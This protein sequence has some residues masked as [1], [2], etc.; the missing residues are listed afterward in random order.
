MIESDDSV[1]DDANISNPDNETGYK[2]GNTYVKMNG[3]VNAI[4]YKR[5]RV[6]AKVTKMPTSRKVEMAGPDG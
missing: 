6:L 5:H 3:H 4:L 2:Y 1:A